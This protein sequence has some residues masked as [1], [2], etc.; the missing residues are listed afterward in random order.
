MIIFNKTVL[1]DFYLWYTFQMEGKLKNIIEEIAMDVLTNALSLRY[2]ICTCNRC[3]NDMLAYVLSRV[4]AKYVTTEAGAL[5]TIID[6]TRVEKEAEIA[7]AAISAIN[8]ISTSPRHETKENKNQTFQ[9]LLNKIYEDRALIFA[10]IIWIYSK[11][12]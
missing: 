7:R 11:D 6:Q 9:L 3:R 5:H 2:D 1:K 8:A 10:T 4:P 12:G